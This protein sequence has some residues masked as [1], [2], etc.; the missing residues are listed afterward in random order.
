MRTTD[1][2]NAR[3]LRSRLGPQL[4]R[5]VL[6]AFGLLVSSPVQA[7]TATANLTVTESVAANCSI[8][9]NTLAFGSYDPV[10][11][12]AASP[13]DG[14][15]SIVVTCTNGA[16]TTVT[17]GQGSN[18]AGGSTDTVPLRRMKAGTSNYLSYTLYQDAGRNTAWGNTSGTGVNHT[19]TGTSTSITVYGRVAA[20]QN[21]PTG[22]YTDTVVA[23]IT[24]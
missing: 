12:H 24:F 19:G 7:G 13:L 18:A 23:T 1:S 5:S 17:L 2:V 15:G 16:S 11:T 14:T 9:T 22:S 10:T 8:S 3:I 21:V 6:V 20:S 4:A